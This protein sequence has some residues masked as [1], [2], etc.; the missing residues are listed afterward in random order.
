M[1]EFDEKVGLG[2]VIGDD[3]A[4]GRG[5]DGAGRAGSDGA[6]GVGSDGAGGGTRYPFHCTQIAGGSRTIDVGTPVSFVVLP[7]R[8]GRW[9]AA[10]LQPIS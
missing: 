10:D 9:E 3:R 6:G 2:T 4:G 5:S 7:G 1:A 8:G